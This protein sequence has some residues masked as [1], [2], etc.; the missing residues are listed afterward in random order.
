[1]VFDLVS[2]GIGGDLIY[3]S[4]LVPKGGPRFSRHRLISV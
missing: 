1:M 2:G 3:A 4:G